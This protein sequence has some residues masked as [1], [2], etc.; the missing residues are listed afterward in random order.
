MD[1]VEL[2]VIKL[3]PEDVTAVDDVSSDADTTDDSTDKDDDQASVHIVSLL[4]IMLK[5][6]WR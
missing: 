3:E 6:R 1:R 5:T 2:D 4:P